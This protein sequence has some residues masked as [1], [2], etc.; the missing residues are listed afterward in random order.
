[1]G[2][3]AIIHSL[4]RTLVPESKDIKTATKEKNFNLLSTKYKEVI[5]TLLLATKG[6]VQVSLI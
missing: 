3:K 2:L 5:W 6:R 4:N 1:M